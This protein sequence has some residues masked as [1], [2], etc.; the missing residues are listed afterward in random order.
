[1]RAGTVSIPTDA[2]PRQW[3]DY[4][5]FLVEVE[6]RYVAELRDYLRNDLGVKAPIVCTQANYGGIAGLVREKPSDFIDA[7]AYWQHPDWGNPQ[8]AWDV[9]RYTI[10]NTSQMAEFSPRWFGEYGG[11][12]LLRV[13]GKPFSVSEV[14]YPAPSDY[15]CEM[16]PLLATFG[17]LQDWDAIYTFDSVAVGE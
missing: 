17:G 3:N 11:L 5:S 8:S 10:N 7:H 6:Q 15:A 12:A 14:D 16:Y 2:T 1:A 9:E 13:T 4:L